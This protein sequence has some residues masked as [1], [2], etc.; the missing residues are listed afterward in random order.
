VSRLSSDVI[1]VGAGPAGLATS[2]ELRRRSIDHAV[3]EKGDSLGHTWANLYDSLVLHTGKHLSA[4]PGLPFSARTP[5]FPPREMFLEYLRQYAALFRLPVRP[6]TPVT[7]IARGDGGWHITTPHGD[8]TAG[9]VVM[10]TGI[11]ANPIVPIFSGRD[12]FRGEVLHSGRY[13]RPGPFAGR[14]VLVVGSGNSAGEIA[15]E[16]AHSGA[17]VTVSVRSGALAVP[18]ELLG[19]PIQYFSIVTSLLPP[20]LQRIVLKSTAK[21]GELRRGPSPL[22]RPPEED[23]CPDVPLIGFHLTDAIRERAIRLAPALESFTTDGVR[24]ADGSTAPFDTVILATGYRPALAPL[25]SLVTLDRC[26]FAR[27]ER[28]VSSPEQSGLFF[29]GQTYDRRGA[30]FNIGRDSR[31]VGKLVAAELRNPGRGR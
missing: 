15:P 1:V 19:L 28:R 18:R 5:L 22:P 23:G 4:L 9:V 26:G 17:D 31:R 11:V 13:R 21:L 3:L 8:L 14:R 2:R 10:A 16:L 25:G 30:L 7:R 6:S 27:R 20:A 12:L 24:F 29:V